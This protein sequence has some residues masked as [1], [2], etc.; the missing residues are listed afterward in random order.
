MPDFHAISNARG[1]TKPFNRPVVNGLSRLFSRLR[2]PVAGILLAG[3]LNACGQPSTDSAAPV[4]TATRTAI[5]NVTLIDAVNGVRPN[6]TVVFEGDE[7]TAVGPADLVVEAAEVIDGAGKFLIPG[8]WD[9][10]VHLSYDERLTEAMPELFLSWGITSVR[11]TGGLMEN[12]LPIVESMRA[13]GAVAPRVFFAGPLLDGSIVVYDGNGRPEIGVSVPTPEQARATVRGLK[14]QGV[15]FIKIYEMTSPDVFAALVEVAEELDLPIDS[16]VPLSMRASEAGPFVDS[17]EHLRNV[18]MDCAAN[19]GQLHQ[20]RLELL[21]NPGQLSGAELRSMLHGLQRL[22]AVQN[23]DQAQCDQTIAALSDTMMVPTLRLNSLNLAPPYLKPDWESALARVPE[24]LRSEW[25][26][27]AANRISEGAGDTAFAEWSLFLTSRMHQAGVPIGAGTDT[28][29]NLS[30]P[31]Y[32]LHSELEMLVRAGLTPLQALEAATLKPA[33]YFSLQ[34]EMGSIE[35]GKRADLVL[36]DANPLDDIS[37]TRLI[38]L[39]ISK[40]RLV[41]R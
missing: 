36:L 32:S 41:S 20:E 6:Q 25:S 31:G 39:V 29:I 11:D 23:Y 40:G 15:D 30:I 21:Q 17:I 34:D 22:S 10:H 4:S 26:T 1:F 18:E 35:T 3:L 8:L 5:Q 12:M 9:F 16:H 33:E 19:A 37:N 7:I 38:D 14:E 2:Q 27:Q 13:P 24:A 28:P